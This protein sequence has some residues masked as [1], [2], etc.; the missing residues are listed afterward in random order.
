MAAALAARRLL[1]WPT[2]AEVFSDA[3]TRLIPLPAFAALLNT[4]GHDAK[5]LYGDG[6]VV[7][8]G[9]LTALVGAAYLALRP[10]VVGR[11]PLRTRWRFTARPGLPDGLALTMLP[12]LLSAGLLAPLVSGGGFGAALPGG[13]WGLFA[14]E[15]LPNA[16]FAA[17][18]VALARRA[19][20]RARASAGR[21]ESAGARWSRRRLLRLGGLGAGALAV[22]ALAWAVAA[23]P[24]ERLLG[25]G[26]TGMPSINVGDVPGK[27]GV[28]TP[29]YTDWTPLLNE[30]PALTATDD[31][32]YVSKNVYG[33][34]TL[35]KRDWRLLVDGMVDA[36]STLT[37]DDLLALPPVT[38]YHTLECISN[39]VGGPLIS[40]ASFV[41]ARVADILQ[42]A[43][44][45]PGADKVLAFAGDAYSESLHLGQ[46]LD[47]R[48]LVVY[49]INGEPLP[50]EHGAP[51]R[52]LVP[53]LYG[54]KNVKWLTRL[55]AAQYDF[56]GFWE[57]RGWSHEARVKTM[58]RIDYPQDG[59]LLV[60]GQ[61]TILGVAYAADRGIAEVDVSTDGGETYH[62]A[63]FHPATLR[64]PLGPLTW[65]IWRYDWTPPAK[66]NY[67]II[68]RAIDGEGNVQTPTEAPPL[69][70]GASGY[71]RVR[72]AVR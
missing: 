19:P 54:M 48:T 57:E 31:F 55:S 13:I 11:L 4:F 37:Y 8:E 43:G 17:A 14:A 60:M 25:L 9:V 12:W 44:V 52:L 34:P 16:L 56:D 22:G 23:G 58:T 30:T 49:L 2:P 32:Y 27:V 7:G 66:G 1:G 47:P 29:H 59:Y 20:L 65:L 71:H 61:T 15:L 69:P 33:D 42:R 51:A 36:P 68:A 10:R 63:T 70:D 24:L 6:L 35:F 50:M 38:R 72:I 62:P 18:L 3:L 28:P 67:V 40:N 45:Q 53:G 21:A 46:A 5:H 39:E 41:G 26:G 64:R